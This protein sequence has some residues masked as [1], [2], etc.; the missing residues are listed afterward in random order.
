MACWRHLTTTKDGDQLED[1]ENY[2]DGNEPDIED[3]YGFDH[4]EFALEHGSVGFG[5]SL[6]L[7]S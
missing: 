1:F 6:E 2:L 3:F 5:A 7:G 4:V